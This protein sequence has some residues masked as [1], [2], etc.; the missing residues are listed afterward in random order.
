MLVR[1][2]HTLLGVRNRALLLLALAGGM[3]R[4]E[5]V[6]LDVPDFTLKRDGLVVTIRRSNTDQ[7]GEGRVL[8]VPVG[9]R[10]ETCPVRAV[11]DW[12]TESG[13]T[14][15]TLFRYVDRHGNVGSQRLSGYGVALTVQRCAAA[16]G[17]VGDYAGH[18][19]RAGL[20]TSAMA[21]SVAERVIA[22]QTGHRSL[23][24]LLRYIRN[25]EFLRENAA[26]SL[27]L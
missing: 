5:V 19:L 3:R 22:K 17:L 27:G 25:D 11:Q 4:N 6:G 15:G 9:S 1:L 12:L 7:T 10:G 14:V 21:S 23:A 18:S 24:N 20:A 16:A 26:A 2:P 8:G 13:L